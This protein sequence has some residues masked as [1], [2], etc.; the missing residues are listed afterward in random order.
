MS[1]VERTQ[2][3]HESQDQILVLTFGRK[4]L[5]PLKMVPLRWVAVEGTEN[6]LDRLRLGG[7]PREQNIRKGHLPR[8]IYHQVCQY[9]KIKGLPV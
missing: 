6:T 9:A 2:L 3:T 1:A 8:V 7:V 4:P 5:K